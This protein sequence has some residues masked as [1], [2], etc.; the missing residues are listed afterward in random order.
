M[1]ALRY[2][3]FVLIEGFAWPFAAPR[4]EPRETLPQA[5]AELDAATR[6][7]VGFDDLDPARLRRHK[8]ASALRSHSDVAAL[9]IRR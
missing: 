7:D 4:P 1:L 5:P 3:R 6:Y 2:I 8:A 9:K